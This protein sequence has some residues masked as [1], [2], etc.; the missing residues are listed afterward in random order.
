MAAQYLQQALSPA[1]A[2][3]VSQDVIRLGILNVKDYPGNP[4]IELIKSI[5]EFGNDKYDYVIL[6]GILGAAMDLSQIFRHNYV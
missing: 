2:M 4:S 6:E 3:L 5:C 1:S